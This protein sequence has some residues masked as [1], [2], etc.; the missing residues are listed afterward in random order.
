MKRGNTT[1]IVIYIVCALIVLAAV[2]IAIW[3]NL[4]VNKKGAGQTEDYTPSA[5]YSE[6]DKPSV[7][8]LQSS[9]ASTTRPMTAAEKND[10]M[11]KL[12]APSPGVKT[13]TSSRGAQ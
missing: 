11:K 7:D 6:K 8:F 9:S 13:A 10:A 2:V 5:A 4:N 3:Y 1:H 12:L